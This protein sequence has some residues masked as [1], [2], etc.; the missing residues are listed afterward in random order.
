[1]SQLWVMALGE[2]TSG[3]QVLTHAEIA[4]V[5]DKLSTEEAE[6]YLVGWRM[7]KV[8]EDI[9]YVPGLTED[10]GMSPA[11]MLGYEHFFA[12]MR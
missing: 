11:F 2:T 3:G 5:Y 6:E 4:K 10:D 12:L 7:A 8:D 9:L 1:M